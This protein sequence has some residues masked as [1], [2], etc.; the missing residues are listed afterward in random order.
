MSPAMRRSWWPLALLAGCCAASMALSAQP[1]GKDK[2]KGEP[3]TLPKAAATTGLVGPDAAPIDLESALRLAGVQNPEI[4]LARER[5]EE[6][7]ALRQL[8]AAQLLPSLNA[9][10]NVNL[11]NGPLQES[12][13]QIIDVHRGS[14]YIGLGASAVGA[15]TV[16]IPGIYWNGNTSEAI[17]GNLVARQRVRVQQFASQAVT[18]DVLLRASGADLELLRAEARLGI[19][20]K[21]R[22]EAAEVAR[23]I[24]NFA[25]K[26][27]ERPADANRAV[28]ELAQRDTDILE[29]EANVLTASA[30]LARL[31]SL[32]PAT[33]LRAADGYA[34][35]VPLVPDSIPLPELLA[36][37]VVQR[38]ELHERQAAIRAALLELQ[39]AKCLPFSPNLILGYSAGDFGG[40]SN[41][42]SQGV[43]QADGTILQQH[44]F[45]N[46]DD[47]QDVDAV[48]YWSLRNLG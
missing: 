5:V 1:P 30:A 28:T 2:Q 9:G 13:G 10:T 35:P 29:A 19:A 40:G 15:G 33:R 38:P 17:F 37:A 26:G 16:T 47:R 12:N 8:A 20:Q 24:T 36:I 39:G 7:A 48:V 18:N 42:V 25:A 27:Q 46:F 6:A 14:M 41:L 3:V 31:L 23:V 21:N 34:V 32:D 44:R 4:L 11:H 43:P 45:G 22:A